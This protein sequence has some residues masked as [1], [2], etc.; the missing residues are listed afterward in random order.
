MDDIKITGSHE[1]MIERMLTAQNVPNDCH[2]LYFAQLTNNSID[3][4]IENYLNFAYVNSLLDIN[5]IIR[6]DDFAYNTRTIK[7]ILNSD[8]VQCSS[9]LDYQSFRFLDTMYHLAIGNNYHQ[10]PEYE[11]NLLY[12]KSLIKKWSH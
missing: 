5:R 7:Y 1:R 11:Q 9:F 3:P 10:I 8:H 12:L 4:T 2:F 6:D